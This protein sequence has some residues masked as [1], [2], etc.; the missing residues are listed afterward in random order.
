MINRLLDIAVR[1]GAT[2]IAMI[3]SDEAADVRAH[4][5]GL[6]LP[7]PLDLLVKSTPSSMHSL[8]ALSPVLRTDQFCL[9]T[10]DSVF[11][12]AEFREFLAF[13]RQSAGADGILALTSFIDDERPLCVQMDEHRRI[14]SFS[15][16]K[17]E[18]QWATGGIYSFSPRVFDSMDEAVACG[19]T[20]LRNFLRF[21]LE[22]QYRLSGFPFSKIVD[23]DHVSDI[24][25][26]EEFLRVEDAGHRRQLVSD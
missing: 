11:R 20:R 21:L 3:I 17:G 26:A 2:R 5:D 12:E 7:I 1:N 16:F 13:C 18:L 14:L 23:V 4:L 9:M 10:T 6:N 24:E 25:A 15:D 22:R 19:V 8:F